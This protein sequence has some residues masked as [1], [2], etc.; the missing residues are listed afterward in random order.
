MGSRSGGG[1]GIY[2]L[3][4]EIFKMTAENEELYD[5]NLF[6]VIDDIDNNIDKN[7]N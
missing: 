4:D 7:K 2:N 6:R 1:G 3:S 5:D